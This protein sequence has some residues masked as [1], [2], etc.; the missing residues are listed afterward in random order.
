MKSQASMLCALAFA[1]VMLLA[2][3]AEAADSSRGQS[4]D[5]L[6]VIAMGSAA[7][8]VP[9]TET[10]MGAAR[11]GGFLSS[12][13]AVLPPN[14]TVQSQ[15]GDSAPVV[16]SGAGP[17][18]LTISTS[19]T[20]VNLSATNPSLSPPIPVVRTQSIVITQGFARSFSFGF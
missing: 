10:E 1:A 5:R 3:A 18:T 17:Q 14:N 4:A 8:A 9:M 15:I 13:L 20:N 2:G 19:T 11:G 6:I 12:L 7:A 16:N